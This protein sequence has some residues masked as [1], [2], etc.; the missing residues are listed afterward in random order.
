[1]VNNEVP[2][3]HLTDMVSHEQDEPTQFAACL[4]HTEAIETHFDRTATDS[5]I[6][7]DEV[8]SRSVEMDVPMSECPSFRF[9]Q[10][11][12]QG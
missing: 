8:H 10:A 1:M 2:C 9:R 7:W 4:R 5:E 3:V 11:L 6:M 12:S